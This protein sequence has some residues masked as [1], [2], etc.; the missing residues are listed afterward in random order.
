MQFT[1]S[2]I[3]EAP[4]DG[5]WQVVAR[6]FD[7]VGDWSSAVAA[8]S[9]NTAA[10]TPDGATVGGRVCATP[11]FGD[12]EETFT[13]YSEADREF[14]FEVDGMP[15][16]VTLARNHTTVRP[17]GADQSEVTLT[18]TMETNT[19]GKVMGPLFS[20]KLK[21][22]LDTFLDELAGYVES[23]EVSAKKSKQLATAR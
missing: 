8:S 23:G 15:S 20:I 6:D 4:T 3:I 18:V 14:T 2:K 9:A 21:S 16:F 5:V 7:R 1:K 17:A 13:S 10:T 12:L 19:I 22:T 11:G